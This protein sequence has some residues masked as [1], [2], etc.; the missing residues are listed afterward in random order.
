MW[1]SVESRTPFSEDHRLIEAVFRMPGVMK[2]RNGVSKYILREAAAP[3]IP[4]SIRT[5]RDKLGYATPNNQW[6]TRL[7]ESFRPYF[8]QDFDGILDK[9]KL[10]KDFDKVFS[11]EGQPE[12]GRIFKFVAFAV[13]RKVM[14]I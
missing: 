1:H 13:W 7:R 11:V 5:R 8:E 9:Q 4:D 6:I 14:G 12:N 2:I 10:L 3:F